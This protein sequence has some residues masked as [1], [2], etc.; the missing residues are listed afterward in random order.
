MADEK[1]PQKMFLWQDHRLF[2]GKKSSE[3][4][5]QKLTDSEIIDSE[6]AQQTA[7]VPPNITEIEQLAA[8]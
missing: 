5:I 3:K 6:G 8:K 1:E 2:R 7:A 4:F